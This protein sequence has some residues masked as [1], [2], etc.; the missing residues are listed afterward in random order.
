MNQLVLY[1]TMV[2]SAV[3]AVAAFT[4]PMGLSWHHPITVPT[5]TELS[6]ISNRREAFHLLFGGSAA[7]ALVVTS[8]IISMPETANAV[9]PALETFKGGKKTKGSFIPGKGLR[10]HHDDELVA[11]NPA[12][13]TFKGGKRTKG[14]FIPGKGLRQHDSDENDHTLFA[15]N[16]ALETFKGR[17]RT[18]GSF[19]PGKGIRNHEPNDHTLFAANPALE[20]FKGRKRT[21][22]SFVPGKGI[23]RR[24]SDDNNVYEDFLASKDLYNTFDTLIAAN[25][26]LETFKGRKRTPGSFMPGKGYVVMMVTCSV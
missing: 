16:P 17:K 13:E 12:L 2:G 10:Q 7:A 9:N 6:A 15:A 8:G 24:H 26:A 19:V 21:P 25:P 11:V 1:V 22:G 5:T 18:P 3:S 20:T 14:A 4:A 23:R